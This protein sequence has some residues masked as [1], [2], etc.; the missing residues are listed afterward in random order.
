[1]KI[2]NLHFFKSSLLL[3]TL[4]ALVVACGPK[5]EPAPPAVA[6][7]ASLTLSPRVQSVS[8]GTS[9]SFVATYVNADGS[10]TTL[11]PALTS[12]QPQL[13][14]V[15]ANGSA[16]AI[17]AGTAMVVA[18]HEGLADTAT[19]NIVAD[20]LGLARISITPDTLEVS[21]GS[22]TTLNLAGYNLLGQTVSLSTTPS[23]S[24]SSSGIGRVSN[25]VFTATNWGTTLVSAR[26]G[27]VVSN[28]TE[29]AVVR[30]GSFRGAE[31]HYGSGSATVKVKNGQVV[32]R[33]EDD[34][35]CQSAP[36]LRVYLSGAPE[37]RAVF[38]QGIEI[39]LLH[40]LRGR[41][42]YLVPANVNISQYPHLVVY[43]RAFHQAVLTTPLQ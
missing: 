33:L 20:S 43:C 13:L 25:G 42:T 12:L 36:D 26:V 30:R 31:N 32:I 28:P 35:L 7:T 1:M 6:T 38:N 34:F 39:A 17:A 21:R 11:V 14:S 22:T 24:L 41:Q 10:R 15:G 3:T 9:L 18:R 40:S 37:M 27:E 8:P 4:V 16:Q 23:W 29:V 5:I 2:M 19:I